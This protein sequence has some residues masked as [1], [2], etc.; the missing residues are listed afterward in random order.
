MDSDSFKVSFFWRPNL[1]TFDDA[2]LLEKFK[3]DATGA[4]DVLYI[5]KGTVDEGDLDAFNR[6]DGYFVYAKQVRHFCCLLMA[7]AC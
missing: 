5:H 3:K 2:V 6:N 4:P 7:L 1:F